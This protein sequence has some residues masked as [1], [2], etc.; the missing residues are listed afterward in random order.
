MKQI[1]N[2]PI[3]PRER[4]LMMVPNNFMWPEYAE[5][6]E[7]YEQ[8]GVDVVVATKDGLMAEPDARNYDAFPNV[9]PIAADLSFEQ[10]KV[11]DFDAVTTVGGNGAWED[12]MPNPQAH[13]ILRESLTGDKVTGL[14]CA[15]TG[16]LAVMEN[17]DGE[18]VPLV[19]G[20]RVTGYYK[21]ESMLKELAEADF[22]EGEPRE[23][24]VVV[25]GNLVTGRNPQSSRLF[26]ETI[27]QELGKRD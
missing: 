10:V 14:I 25:D 1:S 9:K 8:A 19:K 24:T 23:V 18:Q 20:R 3:R 22:V 17:F 15:S 4:L 2:T 11:D 16:T 26:G 5:P 6:R 7:V 12:F 13:R 27:V 21:V